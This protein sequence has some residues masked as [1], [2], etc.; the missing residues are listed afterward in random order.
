[1]DQ[2]PQVGAEEEEALKKQLEEAQ[3]LNQEV[4]GDDDEDEDGDD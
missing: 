1:M 2:Q 4:E 3:R